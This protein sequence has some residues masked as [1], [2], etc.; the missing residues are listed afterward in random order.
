MRGQTFGKLTEAITYAINQKKWL[1]N[2]LQDGK[3]E[4]SNNRAER[5][6]RPFTV[7]R[8]NWL[9]SYCAKGAKASAI[10][11]SIMETAQANGLVPF[12]YL[13]Y[14]FQM[15]PNI[16]AEQFYTCLPWELAVQDACKIPSLREE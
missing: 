15:L 2:F 14:L 7:G 3:L 10:A 6:I 5:S 16:G 9:F 13:E 4:L 8:K 1:L 11:Y 12:K